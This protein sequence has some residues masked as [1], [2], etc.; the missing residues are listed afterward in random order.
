M[1]V[2]G[3]RPD[4]CKVA[5][6]G[7][8]VLDMTK[9]H[10]FDGGKYWISEYGNPENERDLKNL[11]KYS[12]YHNIKN[13]VNHPSML[14]LTAENDDRVHPMHA[15]KYTAKMREISSSKNPIILSSTQFSEALGICSGPFPCN[16]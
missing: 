15:Y 13:N 16:S 7:A 9:Y 8:P 14:L 10:M 2:V 5:V 11:L 4:L 3:Q 6:M 12:P 1:P